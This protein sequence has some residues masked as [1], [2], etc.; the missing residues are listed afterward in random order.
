MKA[1]GVEARHLVVAGNDQGQFGAVT[2]R[3]VP[4]Q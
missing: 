1:S 2:A 3:S 4:A